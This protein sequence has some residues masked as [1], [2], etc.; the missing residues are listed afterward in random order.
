MLS[1]IESGQKRYRQAGASGFLELKKLEKE[2]YDLAEG[3]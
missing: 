1:F 3:G 2:C